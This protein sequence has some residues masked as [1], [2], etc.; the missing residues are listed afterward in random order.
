MQKWYVAKT[1]P[2]KEGI[3]KFFLN[4]RLGV[5]VFLPYI[6]SPATKKPGVELL[7]PTYLFCNIN[8]HTPDWPTIRYAPGLSYFLCTGSEMTPVP[9]EIITRL[10]ERVS[11]W[12]EG[13]FSPEFT[14]GQRLIVTSGPFLGLE[15]I[16]QRYIPSRQRCQVLL[17]V[18]G[19]LAKTEVPLAALAT[20]SPYRELALLT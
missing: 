13:G 8:P 20:K 15:A 18:M 5:E 12:N 9:G 19:S 11:L 3:V 16:F 7:F 10:K 6:N 4:E 2:G 14:P 1:K 17:E